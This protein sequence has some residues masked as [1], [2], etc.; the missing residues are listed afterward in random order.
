M[1]AESP[2]DNGKRLSPKK[3]KEKIIR[4][5]SITFSLYIIFYTSRL[6]LYLDIYL[7]S[8]IHRA[9]SLAFIII[10]LFL[11]SPINKEKGFVWYD[12]IFILMG[13][14]SCV[15]IVVNFGRIMEMGYTSSTVSDQIFGIMGIITILEG[16]RRTI[17]WALTAL[18]ILFIIY[19]F[20]GDYFPG[21]F[22]S[23]GYS[24]PRVIGAV[25]LSPEGIFGVILDIAVVIVALFILFGAF[26]QHSGASDFFMD[27]AFSLAGKQRG[28][29]A[30]IA[31]IASALFGSINGSAVANVASTGIITIPLMKKSGYPP[32]NAAAIES[33]ASTGGQILPP[34]MGAT[35]FV[36]AFFLEVSYIKVCLIALVP[37]ILYFLSLYVMVD[38]K[39]AVLHLEGLP[40]SE[41]PSLRKTLYDGWLFLLPIALLLYLL[42]FKSFQPETAALWSIVSLLIVA[43]IKKKNIKKTLMGALAAGGRGVVEVGVA[44]GAAG[45][46]FGIMSLTGLGLNLSGA[47]VEI[48]HGSLLALLGLAGITS[49]VLGMGMPTTPAYIIMAILVAPALTVFGVSPEQAHL[50]VL[51]C[52]MASMFTP[53]V[54]GAVFVGAA[55][56]KAP[57]F[58]TGFEAMRIGIAIYLIPFMVALSPAFVLSGPVMD[59]IVVI[60]TT[61]IGIYFLGAGLQG[62]L[63]GRSANVLVR[64]WSIC[65]GVL[66]MH[67]GLW[68]DIAG[69]GLVVAW[70]LIFKSRMKGS[71]MQET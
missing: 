15:H 12:A 49:F 25:Y 24:L 71:R 2:P 38:L 14:L 22:I 59:I 48:S 67:P 40:R 26:L 9:I 64:I 68:T 53:P 13:V 29:P 7:Y 23:K 63:L 1:S 62:W 55:I 56:A 51:S 33:I 65:A 41:L 60:V 39:A 61:V 18:C 45:I 8:G 58:K 66:L 69:A 21:V 47:L 35:A 16:V 30:K 46:I 6:T 11:L 28:G 36:M 3:R 42:I 32:H 43:A 44:S 20:F 50:F 37:A 19:G 27:L 52:A 54:C 34:V 10:L 57:F 70:T 5:V 31:V 4:L 17:G